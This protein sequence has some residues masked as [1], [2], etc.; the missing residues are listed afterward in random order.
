MMSGCEIGRMGHL[1]LAK[2]VINEDVKKQEPEQEATRLEEKDTTTLPVYHLSCKITPYNHNPQL[3]LK[4]FLDTN[5]I[6]YTISDAMTELWP[7][8]RVIKTS[9]GFHGE[10]YKKND[11]FMSLMYLGKTREEVINLMY[12]LVNQNIALDLK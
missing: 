1:S 2:T 4:I 3:N 7:Y 8:G 12:R 9:T 11:D 5:K 10:F 6:K